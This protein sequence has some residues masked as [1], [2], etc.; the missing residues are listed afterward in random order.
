MFTIID[1]TAPTPVCHSGLSIDLNS[2]GNVELWATDFDA[3]SFDFCHNIK[4][5]LNRIT[6]QN[7]DG[8]ITE[9]D[10]L[11]NP[12]VN[13]SI[14][15]TCASSGG[16]QQ[17]QLWVGEVSN[18]QQ[19]N[20]DFCTA[21]VEVQDNFNG[22]P[23][24][25]AELGGQ[26][27]MENGR[28][29]SQVEMTLSGNQSQILMTPN[30]GE[31][32][33]ENLISGDDFTVTPMRDDVHNVGI[34]TLDLVLIRQHVLNVKFLDSPYKII[35]ADANLSQSITTLDVVL[36]RKMV[37][38]ITNTL[39]NGNT[40][41][42]FV[43]SDQIFPNPIDPWS[44]PFEEA[45]NINNLYGT[46]IDADFIAIKVGDVTLDAVSYTHLTLPT[47]YPV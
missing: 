32:R 19:N 8:F 18:D 45:I 36:L 21:W 23:G 1:C 24:S 39:P 2:S 37:L 16:L 43:A 30:S 44:S 6:D 28:T 22:C 9:D 27:K 10:Y 34:S 14:Q 38:R 20:W 5:R 15:F 7:N 3:S 12:P 25:R 42:R 47:I 33:F 13:D 40:A 17:V 29:V 31:Y 4:L 11:P 41:W 46:L 35:A 26:V